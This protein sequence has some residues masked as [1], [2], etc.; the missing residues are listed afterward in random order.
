MNIRG[1]VT[2]S[3]VVLAAQLSVAHAQ[4]APQTPDGARP[5][6]DIGTRSSLPLSPNASNIT[7]GDTHSTIAPTPPA[8]NV[9]P[10]ANVGQLL[11]AGRQALAN[12][13]TGMSQEALEEA[14]TRILDRSVLQSQGAQPSQD[15]VVTQ[16]T[17]ARDELG[18]GNKAGALQIINQT[19]G[20][21]APELA[22]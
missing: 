12:N 7:A 10:D 1:I 8:P 18:Q 4:T 2:V 3:A 16:I 6:N 21:G 5:G 14:E 17:Q 15:P 11:M 13:Q 22:D 19:L 20:S 9:G